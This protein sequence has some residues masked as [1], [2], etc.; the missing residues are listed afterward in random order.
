MRHGC[1]VLCF[2]HNGGLNFAIFWQRLSCYFIL[3]HKKYNNKISCAVK[4]TSVCYIH[5]GEVDVENRMVT[6]PAA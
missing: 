2:V 3:C 6:W 4:Q 5:R 1:D